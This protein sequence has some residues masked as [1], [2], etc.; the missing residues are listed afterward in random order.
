MLGSS[1]TTVGRRLQQLQDRRLLRVISTAHW[2]LLTS[3]N[4]Y[5]VWIR[6]E[7]GRTERVAAALS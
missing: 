1:A 6:C 3:G 5:L 2:S 4:P 7:P